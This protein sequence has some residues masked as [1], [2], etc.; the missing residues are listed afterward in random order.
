MDCS[1]STLF[2]VITT[3][4]LN[5]KCLHHPARK[6]KDLVLSKHQINKLTWIMP[7]TLQTPR[8]YTTIDGSSGWSDSTSFRTF[9]HETLWSVDNLSATTLLLSPSKPLRPRTALESPKLAT[10]NSLPEIAPNKQHDPTEAIFGI[11]GNDCFTNRIKSSSVALNALFITSDDKH[12][13]SFWNSA[14]NWKQLN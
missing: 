5:Q 7:L 4:A 14:P 8:Q 12:P 3:T 2:R 9:S 13:C 1:E 10:Y 6:E 11:E